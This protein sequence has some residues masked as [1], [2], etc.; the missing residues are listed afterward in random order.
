MASALA[1]ATPAAMVPMPERATSFTQT[2]ASRIDLLEV[3]DQ[4]RQILDGVDVVM[5]RRRDQRD[6]RRGVA[7]SAMSSVTL[8]PGKLAAFAGLGALRDLDL[9]LAAMF[10]YSAVT[11][12]RA[13]AICL[14]AEEALSPLARGR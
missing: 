12:K 1:L 9:D 13:E 11:P 7:Q 4:L 14:M 10:R 2:R 3:V 5:R 8:K 6:A